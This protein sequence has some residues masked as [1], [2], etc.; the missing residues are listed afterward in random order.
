MLIPKTTL[1]LH[2]RATKLG[3]NKYMITSTQATDV[4]ICLI[5]DART[6]NT[7]VRAVNF[8]NEST[9]IANMM[10]DFFKNHYTALINK[11]HSLASSS[12]GSY[13]MLDEEPSD[14]DTNFASYFEGTPTYT[15]LATQPS[16]WTTRYKY[17]Y[18]VSQGEGNTTVYTPVSI[19][20]GMPTFATNTYYKLEYTCTSVTGS[21]APEFEL[22]KYFKAQT[23]PAEW[24]TVPLFGITEHTTTA[25]EGN[26]PDKHL[27]QYVK[28]GTAVR[29]MRCYVD[30]NLYTALNALATDYSANPLIYY[31][32]FNNKIYTM[33]SKFETEDDEE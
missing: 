18:T 27:I 20:D 1:N 8:Y 17:Y 28:A 31:S 3:A 10:V 19:A 25:G 32:V 15:L 21:T 29:A 22:N 6:K 33:L 26:V 16:D 7:I 2:I 30:A 23:T 4:P 14:W 11:I 5:V 12:V 24:A 9:V 13:Y